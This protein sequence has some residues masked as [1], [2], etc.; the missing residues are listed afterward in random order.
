MYKFVSKF[1]SIDKMN[2]FLE[3]YKVTKLVQEEIEN[4]NRYL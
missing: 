3:R 4:L 1:N 2:T